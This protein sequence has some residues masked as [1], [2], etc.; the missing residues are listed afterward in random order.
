MANFFGNNN[1]NNN[2]NFS[3]FKRNKLFYYVVIGVVIFTVIFFITQGMDFSTQNIGYSKFL[4]LLGECVDDDG[5][6]AGACPIKEVTIKGQDVYGTAYESETNREHQYNFKTVIPS[7]PSGHP[8]LVKKLEQAGINFDAEHTD[9]GSSLWIIFNVVFFLLIIGF[10]VWSSRRITKQSGGIFDVGKS[11]SKKITKEMTNITF[12]DVAGLE[13]VKRDVQEIID[14]LK[15]PSKFRALGATIP[16]GVLL[17]GPPGTGKTLIAKAVAGEA[18]V[19]FYAATGSEFVE[20]FVGVGASRVRDLFAKAR[21]DSPCIV[22][23]DEIDAV[24]RSRGTGLGGGHDEREQTL[25]QLLTEMDGMQTDRSI[26]VMAATNRP[27][28][29]DQALLRPGRFDR[30]VTLDKPRLKERTEILKIHA[31]NKPLNDGVD[32]K[33]IARATPGFS[34]A[35]LENLLNEAAL[36]AGRMNK[37]AVDMEVLNEA[38]DKVLMGDKRADLLSNEEKKITAYHEAGHALVARLLPKTDPVYKITIIPRGRSMGST[39]YLPEKDKFGYTRTELQS[40][41]CSLLAGYL[42]EKIFVGDVSTGASNDIKRATDV[43]RNMITKY[44]MSEEIGLINFGLGE[45][46]IFLGKE[47][48]HDRK[49][50]DITLAEI[51]K[52]LKQFILSCEGQTEKILK[53]NEETMHKIAQFL[54]LNE[55]M[56]NEELEDIVRKYS[57]EA[58][59]ELEKIKSNGKT[60]MKIIDLEES[61]KG[62]ETP[63]NNAQ[64]NND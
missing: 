24:G 18:N 61:S 16:R 5:N 11:K 13:N 60:K 6:R 62:T 43:V 20:M 32:L 4:R 36:L 46:H 22:F 28:V 49:F 17:V 48:G 38:K 57:Q 8:D 7:Q 33:V 39:W 44:G 26:I 2:N 45:E 34:G 51:D 12:K 47:L 50:S 56:T 15:D 3:P 14:F 29:L 63:S 52:V 25:N 10:F 42:S 21:Q 30:Q 31:R 64:S 9:D 19:P 58:L 1:N 53:Q 27:D 23:I 54:Y 35:D 55:E 40:M 37:K 59:S 41:V